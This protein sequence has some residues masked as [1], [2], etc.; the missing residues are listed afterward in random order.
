MRY[1]IAVAAVALSV[2]AQAAGVNKCVGP[3]GK[4]TFTQQAC[5]GGG[6][7]TGVVDARN[8]PPSGSGPAVEMASPEWQTVERPAERRATPVVGLGGG[9]RPGCS[10]GLSEQD[11]RTATVRGQAMQGMTRSQIESIYGKPDSTSTAN[12][13]VNYRYW[14]AHSREYVSVRFDE[15]GCAD[16]VYQSKDN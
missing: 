13:R 4:V 11:E 15:N 6:M 9:S 16:W 12:G 7:P 8:P 14:N 3:D 10:T 2:T 5:P 1:L